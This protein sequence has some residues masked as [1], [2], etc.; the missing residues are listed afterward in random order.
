MIDKGPK[1]VLF[2]KYVSNEEYHRCMVAAL[3][4]TDF[5]AKSGK[6]SSEAGK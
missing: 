5:P 2:G 1:A 4:D 6:H 3:M